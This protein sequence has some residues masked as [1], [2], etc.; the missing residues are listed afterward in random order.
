MTDVVRRYVPVLKE[1]RRVETLNNVE[2]LRCSYRGGYYPQRDIGEYVM[3]IYVRVSVRF[4]VDH[5]VRHLSTLLGRRYIVTC[6]GFG[7]ARQLERSVGFLLLFV[8][9]L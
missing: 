6:K 1:G 5:Y 2:L 4:S 8:G 3:F 7:Y 9:K